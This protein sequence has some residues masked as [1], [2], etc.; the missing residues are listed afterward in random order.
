[1]TRDKDVIVDGKTIGT[2]KTWDEVRALIQAKLPH[3][4]IIRSAS[5]GPTVFHVVTNSRPDD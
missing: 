2:A 3:V 1:M 4:R 5:E